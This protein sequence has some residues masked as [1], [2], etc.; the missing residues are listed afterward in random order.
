MKHRMNDPAGDI[1]HHFAMTDTVKTIYVNRRQHRELV[2][3]VLGIVVLDHRH[4]LVPAA[5]AR[6]IRAID[7][8]AAVIIAK[9]DGKYDGVPDDLVW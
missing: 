2:S 5:I 1:A 8:V 3:G 7:P 9:P 4:H 6:G